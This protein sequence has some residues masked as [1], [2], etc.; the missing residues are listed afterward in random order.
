MPREIVKKPR[1]IY[2]QIAT[3]LSIAEVSMPAE[4]LFW[5]ILPQA[6]DQGRLPGDPRQLKAIACPMRKELTEENIP[7]LL[8]ELEK[9]KLIIRYSNSTTEYIQIAKWWDYQSSM[10]RVF[11]SQYPSPEGWQDQIRGI[12]HVED[13]GPRIA[14]HGIRDLLLDALLK[15]EVRPKR[16][17]VS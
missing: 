7:V 6:D 16:C 4:L 2:P 12:E 3:S 17:C 9:A 8:T 14:E 10:R 11:P 1:F 15:A 13:A 5:R